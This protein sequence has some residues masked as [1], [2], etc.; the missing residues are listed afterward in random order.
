MSKHYGSGLIGLDVKTQGCGR[1]SRRHCYKVTGPRRWL[2]PIILAAGVGMIIL[3][4]L[5]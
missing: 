2:L 5:R 3:V 1:M 4:A